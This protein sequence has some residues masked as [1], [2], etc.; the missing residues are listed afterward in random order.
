MS[1]S[2]LAYLDLTADDRFEARVPRLLKHDAELVA[3]ASGVSLSEY[4]LR[5][6][7]ERVAEELPATQQWR[8]TPAQQ[9]QL[10][11]ILA[12]P[13]EGTGALEAAR[14][15]ALKVFGKNP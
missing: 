6:L 8:L 10:L 3:R 2:A 9:A 5:I 15:R 7:A 1:D 4:V 11:R 13:A 14:K 12:A